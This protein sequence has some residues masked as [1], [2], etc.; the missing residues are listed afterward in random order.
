MP[1]LLDGWGDDRVLHARITVVEPYAFTKVS[2][3]G[4]EE[5]RTNVIADF[6]ESPEPLGDGYRLQAHVVTYSADDA[7]KASAGA[8]FPCGAEWCVFAV[9]GGHARTRRVLVGHRTPEYFEV[10]DGLAIGTQ[11]VCYPPNDLADGSRVSVSR[12][13][14]GRAR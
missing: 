6:T 4:V 1:V 7:I 11:V 9:E 8:L 13:P 10:K 2:A 5:K 12:R 14:S 3:L